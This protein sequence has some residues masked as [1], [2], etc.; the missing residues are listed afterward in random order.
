MFIHFVV[1]TF[2]NLFVAKKFIK[3][4]SSD[5][6]NAKVPILKEIGIRDEL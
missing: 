6:K 2:D 4:C 1:N 3:R 5:D